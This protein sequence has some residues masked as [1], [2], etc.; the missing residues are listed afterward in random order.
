MKT[1]GGLPAARRLARAVI[2]IAVTAAVAVMGI[3]AASADAPARPA[4]AHGVASATSPSDIASRYSG[5]DRYATAV[6]LSA[7][8]AP[9]SSAVFVATGQDFPDALSA[10][11][12]AAHLDAPLLLTRGTLLP[13]DVAAE[14]RRLAPERIYLV[15]GTGVVSRGVERVLKT[16]GPVTRLAGANRYT[17]AAAVVDEVFESAATVFLATG[18]D[19]PDALAA[20]GAAAALRAP[21]LLIDGKQ[22]DVTAEQRARIRALGAESVRIVGGSNVVSPAIIGSLRST[23]DVQVHAGR[24]RYAT[25]AAVNDAAFGEG[26]PRAMFASGA[27]FPDALAGA[28]FAGAKRMPVYPV[29]ASCVDA[30]TRESVARL[31]ANVEITAVGG[32]AVVSERAARQ[33]PCLAPPTAPLA[34][35]DTTGFSFDATAAAPYSDRA[36]AAVS[37]VELDASD[38]RV[39]RIRG[40]GV[41]ADHPVVYAQYGISALL[42]YERTGQ[43]V[44]LDRAERQAE[45]LIAMRAVSG[46]AWWFPYGFAWTYYDRTLAAP[47]WSAMAQGQALSLFTRLAQASDDTRWER[48][49]QS[50][51]RSFLQ[52][53]STS[54]PWSSV[55]IDGSLYLEEYAGGQPPLQVLNGQLFAAFG[56]YDYWRWTGDAEVAR[57]LDGS[58]TTVLEM[59]PKIRVPG[60]VSVYCAQSNYCERWHHEKYHV[61]HSWQ[62]DTA[63]R[64]TGDARFA[65]WAAQLR[66]DWAPTSQF[67]RSSPELSPLEADPLDVLD[68]GDG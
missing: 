65:E 12:A 30:S 14:L 19:Y 36:P 45:G 1:E 16:I 10:A 56:L 34:A 33:I 39:Y 11:A 2:A 8:H 66:S 54:H 7:Q 25:A 49:A 5:T 6:A 67:R 59:M 28:A 32:T 58:L 41:A 40:T 50:T 55:I 31:S 23:F 20:S 51:W 63:A 60:G 52:G 9:G 13:P 68:W 44:W 48:A 53:R 18:R 64:L 22:A 62:L 29:R 61:I 26:S 3:P 47:W 27:D 21:V 38:L 42:E 4:V 57:L 35:F 46:D 37:G 24:D 43:Q 15:G 17:T